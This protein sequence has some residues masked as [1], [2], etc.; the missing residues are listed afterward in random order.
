MFD[1]DCV[2]VGHRDRTQGVTHPN[3]SNLL[4][5][6]SLWKRSLQASF[7]PRGHHRHTLD[8]THTRTHSRTQLTYKVNQGTVRNVSF[9]PPTSCPSNCYSSA[10]RR[11]LH[12]HYIT[13]SHIRKGAG[14]KDSRMSHMKPLTALLHRKVSATVREPIPPNCDEMSMAWPCK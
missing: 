11:S 13:Q 4:R 14:R 8:H 9:V 10:D 5:G 12:V 6:L 2:S 7:Y 3:L 1:P